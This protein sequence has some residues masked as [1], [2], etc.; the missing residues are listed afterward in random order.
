MHT[1]II[2]TEY[3]YRSTIQR[4]LLNPEKSYKHA[5]VILPRVRTC[6]FSA[7]TSSVS[8]SLC[9]AT[10]SGFGLRL[11][12]ADRNRSTSAAKVNGLV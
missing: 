8:S 11:S 1:V 6:V 2:S 3:C 10:L 12:T 4:D 7:S 5:R 9:L